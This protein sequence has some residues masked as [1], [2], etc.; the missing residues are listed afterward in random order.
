MH[1]DKLEEQCVKEKN[2][3]LKLIMFYQSASAYLL[4]S[5]NNP[6]IDKDFVN[7]E[8]NLGVDD[9][10]KTIWINYINNYKLDEDLEK[11]VSLIRN[12]IKNVIDSSKN[13]DKYKGIL[14]NY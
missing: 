11:E 6:K 13:K 7:F 2:L 3:L 4:E 12:Q 5:S 10:Y 8:D 1:H 9:E 14:D